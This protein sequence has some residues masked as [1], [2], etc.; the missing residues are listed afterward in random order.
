[1]KRILTLTAFV[2]CA[3]AP[4]AAQSLDDLNIQLHGYAT[5]A[6]LYSNVNSWNTTDSE[7]GSASWTEAVV[8]LTAQ[9]DSKLRI[10]VQAR[11]FSLGDYGQAFTLDW[12]QGD[13]KFNNYIG[14][15]AGKVKTPIGLFN[16]T[17][18]IDPAHL[19]VLLPQGIYPITSRD[20]TLAHYGGVVYGA[21]PIGE[22]LGTIEYRGFV[23]QRV[24][25]AD[26]GFLQ[27]F[28]NQGITVPNGLTGHTGGGTLRWLT[29][30]RGLFIGA[31]ENSGTLAGEL[32]DGA[33]SGTSSSPLRQTFFFSKFEHRKLMLAGEYARY[34]VVASS[35]IG[36]L[37]LLTERSDQRPWYLM[38]T[39]KITSKLSTGIYYSSA[40]DR[41]AAFT[42]YRHQKDWTLAARYDFT[43]FLYAKAEQHWLDGTAVGFNPGD[44]PNIVSGSRLSLLKLGV[45]F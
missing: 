6:F 12:A 27:I 20:A 28:E 18:D 44:N 29:P 1:M 45:S 25:S 8:N 38:A 13:Y 14:I 19:W 41:Q 9:P 2:L 3:S 4:L 10:G 43:T 23:G 37:P 24:L 40:V 11:F 26:D 32:A 30:V 5:Q 31:S 21:I 15:R 35:Q 36:P 33:Y 7:D 16:E 22:A 17:Q 39:C 42:T 34:L